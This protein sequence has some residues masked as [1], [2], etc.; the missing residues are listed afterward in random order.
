MSTYLANV[1]RGKPMRTQRLDLADQGVR[2]RGATAAEYVGIA[3]IIGVVIAA[4]VVVISPAAVVPQIQRIWCLI[5]GGTNCA[6]STTDAIDAKLPECE[7]TSATHTGEVEATVFSVNVG[8]NGKATLAEKRD[9][10]GD[11]TFSVTLEGGGKAGV[12][13][14]VGEKALGEGLAAE[15]KA[16]LTATGG[17]VFDFDTRDQ[18]EKFLDYTRDEAEK[19][20]YKAALGP[21]AQPL[22][23]SRELDHKNYNP[24]PPA[25]YYG[26]L[27]TSA[28]GS[29]SATLPAGVS[30]ELGASL[31]LSKSDALGFRFTPAKPAT[32]GKEAEPETYTVYYKGTGELTSGLD[33]SAPAGPGEVEAGA[34]GE[35]AVETQVAVTYEKGGRPV[36]AS[37]E[38][39]GKLKTSLL[40]GPNGGAGLP[41]GSEA[42]PVDLG[43]ET[44]ESYQ[45]KATLTLD[46]TNKENLDAVADVLQS[47][48][49]P[50]LPD[51]GT[52]SDPN[53]VDAVGNLT[54]RFT[55]AG[56]LGGASFTTQEFEAT[57]ESSEIGAW[58]GAELTFGAG[59]KISTEHLRSVAAA[60]YDPDTGDM[61]R[62]IRCGG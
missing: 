50:V 42:E 10:L 38:A 21:F 47:T 27:G 28:S 43:V 61:V 62:W 59:G 31:G 29:L 4:L 8:V 34:S 19:Q 5:T 9:G 15:G 40:G 11:T 6:A 58:G 54:D 51:H 24:P 53:P 7:I 26:E 46:L 39:A 35:G 22:I 3:L 20:A 55:E 41:L 2:E 49:L 23:D 32:D 45:G 25:E 48:G 30:E 16:A 17:A 52:G 13:G 36:E 12:H 33:L 1:P 14:M 37:I 57:E 44:L 56:P 18:A 60:R